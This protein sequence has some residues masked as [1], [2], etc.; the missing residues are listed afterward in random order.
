M[1]GKVTGE[2]TFPG[3]VHADDLPSAVAPSQARAVIR[4]LHLKFVPQV[5]P[6]LQGVTVEFVNDDATAHNIFSPT[7]SDPFDLGTFGNGSRSHLFRTPGVHV[8]LCNIH[9]EMVAWVLVLRNPAFTS[10]AQDGSFEF[11]LPPGHHKLV[12]WRPRLPEE[13]RE[14]DVPA[15]GALEVNWEVR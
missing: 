7:E 2:R 13:S 6:V 14:I 12:L 11:R 3:V 10:L 5:L 9:L 8:I 15:S 1:R 4:Q